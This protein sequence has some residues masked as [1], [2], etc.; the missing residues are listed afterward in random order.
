MAVKERFEYVLG[1]SVDASKAKS[2]MNQLQD[3]LRKIATQKNLLGEKHPLITSQDLI[4]SGK[5]QADFLQLGTV[6]K[7]SFNKTTG[8]LNL[9]KMLVELDK[10]GL[11]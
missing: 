2:E 3:Q 9:N 7:N 5:L 8:Q 1:F 10:Y 4:D 11:K 6:L